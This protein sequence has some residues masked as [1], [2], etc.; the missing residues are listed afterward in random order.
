VEINHPFLTEEARPLLGP[1]DGVQG[2]LSALRAVDW[3]Q[4]LGGLMLLAGFVL[5][6]LGWLG[7]SGT[8]RTADELSYMLAGG[9]GGIALVATGLTFMIAH[10]HRADR[11]AI[12]HLEERLGG[13]EEALGAEFDA[14]REQIVSRPAP[15]HVLQ[16]SLEPAGRPSV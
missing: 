16:G 5:L 8:D 4:T 14:V 10:E 1:V 9:L 15:E 3:R 13:L 2:R 6:C 12:A 11:R 7:V